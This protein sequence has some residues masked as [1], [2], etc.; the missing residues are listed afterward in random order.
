M[1]SALTE[2]K[3]QWDKSTLEFQCCVATVL[4]GVHTACNVRRERT[5][6]LE[7]IS[8]QDFSKDDM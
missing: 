8:G 7:R 2:F 3:E 5:S 1:T 4:I 6:D